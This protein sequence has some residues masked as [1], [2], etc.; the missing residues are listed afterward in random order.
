MVKILGHL[1][2]TWPTLGTG[3][4]RVKILH[5]TGT[6]LTTPTPLPFGSADQ[7]SLPQKFVSHISFNSFHK[8]GHTASR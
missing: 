1:P 7:G 8:R 3:Y 5:F 4:A 2:Q 6:L